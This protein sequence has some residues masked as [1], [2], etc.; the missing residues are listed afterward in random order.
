M[1]RVFG[2]CA[3]G[4]G[5]R[6]TCERRRDGRYNRRFGGSIMRIHIDTAPA[7]RITDI[8]V[9]ENYVGGRW[10][11]ATTEQ[12]RRRLQPGDG[13]CHRADAAVDARRPRCRGPGGEERVS[14][15]SETPVVLRARAIFRFVELL[16]EH[17]EEYGAHGHDRA[18]QDARRIA[19]QRAAR[20]RMRRGRLRRAVDDDGLR[21]RER[22]HRTSTAW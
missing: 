22:R 8:E 3:H 21:P 18:R 2:I 11:R 1:T 14:R 15:W 20:H 12:H 9:V 19:R 10:R 13:P 16:E 4:A 5:R 6:Q 17:V 7:E